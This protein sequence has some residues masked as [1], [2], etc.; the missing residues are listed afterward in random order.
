MKC[1]S[2]F[3]GIGG[4][5]LGL[6]RA[7]FDVQ[8]Q[9]EIDPFC[10]KVLAKHWPDV[11]RYGDVHDV[12]AHNLEPVDL[13][14]GGFPCQDISSAN[15]NKTGI[16]G[17]RSGLW[18][19]YRRVIHELRPRYVLVENVSSLLAR[20][21]GRVLG[22]LAALGYDA[23]WDVLPA[24]AVGSPQ[25]RERVF[26]VAHDGGRGRERGPQRHIQRP[27]ALKRDHPDGLGLAQRRTTDARARLLR[28]GRGLP[29]RVDRVRALG[30]SVHPD[31][32]EWI[33][34]RIMDAHR[35]A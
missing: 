26:I 5:D 7:G 23:E 24:C 35:E 11:K 15:P 8:W 27:D 22:D 10:R 28:M 12:G 3:S 4:M 16:D 25:R 1:G 29:G 33:G 2:L 6:E 31:A 14:C 21:L 30:N 34:H 9:V 32:A 20:G 19:G 13:I 18:S 17:K